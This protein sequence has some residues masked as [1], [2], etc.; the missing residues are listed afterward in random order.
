MVAQ[1]EGNKVTI[2]TS[3][4]VPFDARAGVCETLELPANRTCADCEGG[5]GGTRPTWASINCG[6][7]ICMRCAGVHRA[8]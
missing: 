2:W 8:R 3:T 5:G 7:F 1:W 6:V 4:Q